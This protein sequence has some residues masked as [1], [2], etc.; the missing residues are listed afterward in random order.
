[1]LSDPADHRRLTVDLSEEGRAMFLRLVPTALE[2]STD[3]WPFVQGGTASGAGFAD[4]V[5]LTVPSLN[6]AVPKGFDLGGA[7]RV[8]GKG[9][10]IGRDAV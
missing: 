9:E 3:P 6:M 7:G 8:P 2:L 1:L 10:R 4:A 5:R